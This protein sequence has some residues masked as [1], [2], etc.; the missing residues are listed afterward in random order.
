MNEELRKLIESLQR[1][2]DYRPAYLSKGKEWMICYYVTHPVRGVRV[3]KKEMLNH[4][5]DRAERLRFARRRIRELNIALALGWSPFDPGRDMRGAKPLAKAFEEFLKA[6]ERERIR[7]DSMRSYTSMVGIL[8]EWASRNGLGAIG[9]GEF[10]S[11]HARRFMQDSYIDRELSPR[12]FNNYH[13]FYVTLWNWLREHGYLR[14]NVFHGI[15]KKRLDPDG[16]Q[17]RS[18]S[19]H[20]RAQIR[21][22]L[23]RE[24]PRFFAFCLLCFHCGIRPKE[25]FMLKPEHFS[26]PGR[27][28]L[29]PGSVAKNHRTQGVA[30]PEVMVPN[31]EGL[32]LE[33]Q[34]PEHYVFSTG[35]EPGPK[36]CCSRDSGRAWTRMRQAIGLAKEVTMYQL[37]HAGGEQLSR[38]GVGEVDL[39]NHLRHHDLSETS[40][41]TR[42][43]YKMGV[44]DVLKK[45]SRF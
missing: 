36:L 30:I 43:T 39:M 15:K 21:A 13:T 17:R 20:E 45:A 40:T 9:V 6:K 28:I 38:D 8:R 3:R 5:R 32:R 19:M 12:S 1:T 35:F 10:S 31:L 23:E 29:V 34:S 25:A 7:P 33:G 2:Q 11:S 27:F 18:P 4:I 42:R 22:Y 37:K 44:R 14:E 16:S 41:Y 24:N 26:I